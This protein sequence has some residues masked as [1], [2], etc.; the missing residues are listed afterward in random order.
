MMRKGRVLI[1]VVSYNAK[2]FIARVLDRIPDSVWHNEHFDA[3][4]LII[5]DSSSDGTFFEAASY[6][7]N[8]PDKPIL[9]LHN[10]QNQGYG[11]NQKIGY[12][13]AIE[14]KFDAVLLLHG[15]G[16]YPSE[17][18]EYMVRPILDDES[19]AAF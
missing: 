2:H 6:I 9:L 14:N 13:Y 3:Q 19:D 12:F 1:L 10:P 7:A 16:Q 11:G 4:C 18:I 8:G 15:D 5:D 17:M